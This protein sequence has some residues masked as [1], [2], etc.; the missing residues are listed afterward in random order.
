MEELQQELL[1]PE[2]LKLEELA[3]ELLPLWLYTT[4]LLQHHLEH[5]Q[6]HNSIN[7]INITPTPT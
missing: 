2:L 7:Y 4:N 5:Y 3:T 6:L 1:A